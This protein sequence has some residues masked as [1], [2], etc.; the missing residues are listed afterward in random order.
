MMV[1]LLEIVMARKPV[2]S[3]GPKKGSKWGL[4]PDQVSIRFEAG[5]LD[6]MKAL[7][8][9]LQAETTLRQGRPWSL[10]KVLRFALDEGLDAVEKRYGRKAR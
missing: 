10:A 1:N 7:V 8:P 9:I 2:K 6:R 4:L 3:R 5:V